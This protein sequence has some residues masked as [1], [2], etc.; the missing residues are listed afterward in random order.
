M[1]IDTDHMDQCHH[2]RMDSSGRIRLPFELRERLGLKSGDSV[3]VFQEDDDVRIE[4]ATHAL[5]RAQEYFA[6][7]V[8]QDVSLVEE[9]LEER[10]Q[11]AARE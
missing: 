3:V 9:L 2:V 1:Q 10:R 7:F 6:S 5:R 11:E 8:P 4:T